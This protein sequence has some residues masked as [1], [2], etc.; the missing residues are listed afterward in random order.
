MKICG[1]QSVQVAR[2]DRARSQPSCAA[3]MDR[4]VDRSGMKRSPRE[5]QHEKL[6]FEETTSFAPVGRRLSQSK[7][8]AEPPPR[9]HSQS[10]PRSSQNPDTSPDPSPS[11][12]TPPGSPHAPLDHVSKF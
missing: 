8:I 3:G 1:V 7:A 4:V 9:F 6:A 2:R 10:L 5:R 12:D 11:S